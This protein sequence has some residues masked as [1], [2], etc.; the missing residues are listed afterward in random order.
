MYSLEI[1]Q[2][3]EMYQRDKSEVEW[4]LWNDL[5]GVEHKGERRNVDSMFSGMNGS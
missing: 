2:T 3:G 1:G 5:E 4:R